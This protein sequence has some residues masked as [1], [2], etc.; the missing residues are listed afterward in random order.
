MSQRKQGRAAHLLVVATAILVHIEFA[1]S[2]HETRPALVHRR[3]GVGRM[4]AL[5]RLLKCGGRCHVPAS[6]DREGFT[7]TLV[8]DC[9]RE[10]EPVCLEWRVGR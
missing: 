7:F 2:E 3:L 9:Y 8:D 1:L 10:Y 5:G 4:D 6:W